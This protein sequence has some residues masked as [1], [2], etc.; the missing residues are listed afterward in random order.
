MA[1]SSGHGELQK[2][3]LRHMLNRPKTALSKKTEFVK[4]HEANPKLPTFFRN[5]IWT[6]LTPYLKSKRKSFLIKV[7]RNCPT[8]DNNIFSVYVSGAIFDESSNFIV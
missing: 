8:N 1:P 6:P 5:K 2:H 4:F 3:F 7:V